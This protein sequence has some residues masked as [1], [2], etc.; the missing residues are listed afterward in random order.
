MPCA[1]VIQFLDSEGT[2]CS[3]GAEGRSIHFVS[4]VEVT[5][6]HDPSPILLFLGRHPSPHGVLIGCL[7]RCVGFGVPNPN[8][9]NH[10]AHS[11][12]R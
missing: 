3:V 9:S 2:H 11:A 5:A 8:P 10:P 7:P 6:R 12:I 1:M 4:S